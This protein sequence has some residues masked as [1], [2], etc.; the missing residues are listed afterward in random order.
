MKWYLVCQVLPIVRFYH[1]F[2]F[3]PHRISNENSQSWPFLHCFRNTSEWHRS[4]QSTQCRSSWWVVDPKWYRQTNVTCH[5]LSTHGLSM[6][7]S[8]TSVSIL[9]NSSSWWPNYYG[10]S[11][12]IE[13]GTQRNRGTF[14]RTCVFVQK[15]IR[16][17]CLY[18][19]HFQLFWHPTLV[20]V[21]KVPETKSDS[22]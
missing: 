7:S 4:G 11:F 16:Y 15:H 1:F 18:S 6:S 3:R 9:F 10:C 2:N 17:L 8:K 21:C 14:D 22:Q 5:P 20:L 13:L 19:V 12:P